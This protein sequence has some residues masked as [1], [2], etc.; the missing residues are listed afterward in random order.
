[1]GL[2]SVAHPIFLTEAPEIGRN[3]G[4]ETSP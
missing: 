3:L 4:R 1:M 2:F